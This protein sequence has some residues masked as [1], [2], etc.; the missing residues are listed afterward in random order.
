MIW[1]R[2]SVGKEVRIDMIMES[3]DFVRLPGYRVLG[4]WKEVTRYLSAMF[5]GGV[6][7]MNGNMY[8]TP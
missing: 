8:V 3:Y 2:I 1:R 5:H 6:L 4:L 7:Y